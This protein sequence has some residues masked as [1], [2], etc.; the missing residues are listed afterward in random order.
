LLRKQRGGRASALGERARPT[1]LDI[2]GRR[3][4]QRTRTGPT[5][6]PEKEEKRIFRKTL[7]A[8]ISRGNGNFA[9]HIF[10]FQ[11]FKFLS[12]LYLVK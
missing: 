7:I 3:A 9:N 5:E 8:Q 4:S 12:S 1:A 6:I 11:Q 10:Y 2:C